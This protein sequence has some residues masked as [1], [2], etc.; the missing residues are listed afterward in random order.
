MSV[1]AVLLVD[2]DT[3]AGIIKASTMNEYHRGGHQC[4]LGRGEDQ[5]R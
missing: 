4:G 1:V 2:T 5:L 3:I